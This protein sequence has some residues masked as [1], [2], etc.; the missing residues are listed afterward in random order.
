[1]PEAVVVDWG[2][3]HAVGR[4]V[5]G[6]ERMLAPKLRG[7]PLGECY[8]CCPEYL[9]IALPASTLAK[10]ERCF[11]LGVSKAGMPI[12][13]FPVRLKVLVCAISNR[14]YRPMPRH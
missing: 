3:P 13:F 5:S 11:I 12:C 2:F 7:E 1:M 8:V 10:P 6:E 14:V 9:V 4:Q